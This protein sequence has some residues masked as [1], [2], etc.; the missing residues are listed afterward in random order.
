MRNSKRQSLIRRFFSSRLFL[1]AAL[2][3][4]ILF[5]VGYAR[6]YY[7]DYKIKD[8][9]KEL[10]R[11]LRSLETKKIESLEI[12]QYVSSQIFVEDKA[13]TELN[14]QKSGE[15]VIIIKRGDGSEDQGEN[16]SAAASA[17]R[18]SNLEKWLLFLLRKPVDTDR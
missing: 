2:I 18:L 9:I 12:L 8:E 17:R 5:A 14:L 6:A 7:Q 13:R 10:E 16:I 3:I 15:K 11:E 4:L 1:I